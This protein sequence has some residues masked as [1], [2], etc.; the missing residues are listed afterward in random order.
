MSALEIAL[1]AGITLA[2]LVLFYVVWDFSLG[3]IRK[4]VAD[5]ASGEDS[6]PTEGKVI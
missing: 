5:L 3:L 1:L 6:T 2:G 4:A